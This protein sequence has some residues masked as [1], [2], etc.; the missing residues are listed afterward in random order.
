MVIQLKMSCS[1][2]LLFVFLLYYYKCVFYSEFV[3]LK[4]CA[5]FDLVAGKTYYNNICTLIG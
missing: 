5:H 2:V 3:T 4:L 1:L